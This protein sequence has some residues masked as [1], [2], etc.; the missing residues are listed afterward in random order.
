MVGN[1]VNRMPTPNQWILGPENFE[2]GSMMFNAKPNETGLLMP[3]DLWNDLLLE[4]DAAPS[5]PFSQ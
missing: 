4:S 2:D 3:S 1:Q 5:A